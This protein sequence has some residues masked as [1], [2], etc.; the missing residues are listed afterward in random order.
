MVDYFL[1]ITCI[2]W[3]GFVFFLVMWGPWWGVPPSLWCSLRPG[4]GP[5][6]GVYACVV[7][8]VNTLVLFEGVWWGS[9]CHLGAPFDLGG[10][11]LVGMVW[12]RSS[13]CGGIFFKSVTGF[14]PRSTPRMGQLRPQS[15]FCDW[16]RSVNVHLCRCVLN[17][18]VNLQAPN[19]RVL[20]KGDCHLEQVSE[21]PCFRRL[22]CIW[23]PHMTSNASRR[24][25]YCAFE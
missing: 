5:V 23:T 20:A 10:L 25:L 7:G 8:G 4:W 9:L 13:T 3:F 22:L 2:L 24:A 21:C 17:L 1:W 19:M 15:D 14:W 6:G 18:E 16:G 12:D 11:W